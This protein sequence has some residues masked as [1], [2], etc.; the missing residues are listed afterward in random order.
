MEN[1][2]SIFGRGAWGVLKEMHLDIVSTNMDKM[3]CDLVLGGIEYKITRS[4]Y[5]RWHATTMGYWRA[6]N[7]Q[8]D[9]LGWVGDR[10]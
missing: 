1:L 7:S 3:T 5:R 10:L 6:F 8:W 4:H 9:L 2:S